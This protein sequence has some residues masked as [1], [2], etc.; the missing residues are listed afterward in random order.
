MIFLTLAGYMELYGIKVILVMCSG[1]EHYQQ[2]SSYQLGFTC[3]KLPTPSVAIFVPPLKKWKTA[4]TRKE[5]VQYQAT[6]LSAQVH[7][8]GMYP[9]LLAHM[10]SLT[11]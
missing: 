11:A 5:R 4:S 2:A 9:A 8:Q 10:H 1:R 7:T 3:C 6:M